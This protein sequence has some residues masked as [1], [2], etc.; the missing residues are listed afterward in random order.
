MT[1]D[2]FQVHVKKYRNIVNTHLK[3]QKYREASVAELKIVYAAQLH[4]HNKC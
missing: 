3:R 1:E 4:L 2:H